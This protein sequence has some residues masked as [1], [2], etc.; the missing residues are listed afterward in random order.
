MTC[1]LFLPQKRRQCR[2]PAV[3]GERFCTH[4]R[5]GSAAD[6][7]ER[8][9]CPLDPS[10]SVYT[11]DLEA[12]LKKC[13]RVR[14]EGLVRAQPFFREG[15]HRP[16]ETAKPCAPDPWPLD[17]WEEVLGFSYLVADFV[18]FHGRRQIS[19]NF[20]NILFRIYIQYVGSKRN[21]DEIPEIVT[22]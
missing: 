19:Q 5:E 3:K 16:R 8:V 14:A 21:A 20:V 2:F 12:H 7:T 4:H 10:H 22:R 6:N 17:R 13:S 18:K 15:V 9:P 1:E 11:R